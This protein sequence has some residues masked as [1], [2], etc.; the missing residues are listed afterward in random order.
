MGARFLAKPADDPVPRVLFPQAD[1]STIVFVR[2]P[3]RN[4]RANKKICVRMILM[5][6]LGG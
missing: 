2:F 3:S 5:V 6:V 4:C 1:V